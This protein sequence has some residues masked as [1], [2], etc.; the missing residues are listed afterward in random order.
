MDVHVRFSMGL[1]QYVGTARL[2]VRLPGEA[3]VADLMEQLCIEHP[4][5]AHRLDAAVPVVAGRHV[6]RAEPLADGQEVA[7]LVPIAGGRS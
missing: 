3:T 7:F 1:A 2:T 6:S 5:L 4:S